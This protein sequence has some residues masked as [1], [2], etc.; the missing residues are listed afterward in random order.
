MV[1]FQFRNLLSRGDGGGG[2]NNDN[3]ND[4]QHENK[5]N[6]VQIL[7][8]QNKWNE[9]ETNDKVCA[10][11]KNGPIKIPGSFIRIN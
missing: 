10:G 4:D 9:G 11:Q 5:M 6:A 7:K 3:A 8:V 1:L 2:S